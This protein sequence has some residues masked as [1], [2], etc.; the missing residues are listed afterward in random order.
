M[1]APYG[2]YG[3]SLMEKTT[4]YLPR[5]LQV[6]LRESAR[7]TGRSQADVVRSALDRYLDEAPV[8]RPG[9]IGMGSDAELAA[10]DSEAWL[11]REW[12]GG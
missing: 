4:L 1:R 11:E 3:A 5:T 10:R 9:F 12:S 7:R 2:M 6:R 8:G